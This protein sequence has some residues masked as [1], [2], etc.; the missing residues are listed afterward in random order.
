[1]RLL[2]GVIYRVP[3]L[4]LRSGRPIERVNK[5]EALGAC[6]L[7]GAWA[8]LAQNAIAKTVMRVVAVINRRR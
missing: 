4:S 6:M 1:M 3:A 5:K 8:D 7:A 2:S